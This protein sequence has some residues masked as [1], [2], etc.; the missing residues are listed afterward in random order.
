MTEII[1]PNWKLK[2]LKINFQEYG[3]FKGKYVG[4]IEFE[5]DSS[6]AFMFNLSPEDT[7]AYM[8]LISDKLV[9]SASHLGDKLL[10]SLNLLSAPKE[11]LI[12]Q[13]SAQPEP[14]EIETGTPANPF[15][16]LDLPF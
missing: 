8:N 3:E 13:M 9:K 5:N 6:E 12:D 15:T 2:S 16:D 10:T 1:T 4:K 11:I 7:A 14:I